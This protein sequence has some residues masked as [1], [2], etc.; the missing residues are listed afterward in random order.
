MSI[1]DKSDKDWMEMLFGFGK[2]TGSSLFEKLKGFWSRN[3][4]R[5]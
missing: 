5:Y 1:L 3:M 4:K 2:K